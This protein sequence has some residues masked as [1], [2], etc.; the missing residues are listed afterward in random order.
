MALEKPP[1]QHQID[2]EA[3]EVD[4]L[5]EKSSHGYNAFLNSCA[6]GDDNDT[7]G[8]MHGEQVPLH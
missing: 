8:F 3:G 1:M 7:Q 2:T 4:G 5:E 6:V